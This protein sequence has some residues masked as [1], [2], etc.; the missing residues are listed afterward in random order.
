MNRRNFIASSFLATFPLTFK[1]DNVLQSILPHLTQREPPNSNR[2][3]T[4]FSELDQL[5]GGFAPGQLILIAS[6]P[7]MGKTSF[8]TSILHNVSF[9]KRNVAYFSLQE[10][11]AQLIQYFKKST[12]ILLENRLEIDDTYGLNPSEIRAKCTQLKSKNRLDLVV[13]DYLQLI[14][15]NIRTKNRKK[16][17]SNIC[18]CL[19]Q[20][21]DDLQV[22]IILLSQLRWRPDFKKRKPILSDI[23]HSNAI[24]KASDVILFLHRPGYYDAD[25]PDNE[26]FVSVA[27]NRHGSVGNLKLRWDPKLRLADN[28]TT[29]P[30]TLMKL[31]L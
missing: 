4:G 20:L 31:N 25:I 9:E 16:S 17:I 10:T 11:D 28:L 1:D 7:S 19:K 18:N 5:V 13:L 6:P 27:K 30:E 14:T 26:I 22:P 12:A 3:S 21:A 8:A 2:I 15:P 24:E 23:G 29:S